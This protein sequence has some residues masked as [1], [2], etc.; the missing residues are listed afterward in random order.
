MAFGILEIAAIGFLFIISLLALLGVGYLFLR[1]YDNL[2]KNPDYVQK[3]YTDG[4]EFSKNNCPESIYNFQLWVATTE[5]SEGRP[6]GR[7]KGYAY[8]PI[9]SFTREED[10]EGKIKLVPEEIGP[11]SY[12]HFI[13]FIPNK[14]VFN[15][16]NPTTW[17]PRHLVAIVKPKDIVG[18]ELN[19][20]LHWNARID[21]YKW[22][23]YAV[24]DKEVNKV[25]LAKK[26]ES[27]VGMDF[28]TDAY[29]K[30]SQLV[31]EAQETDSD[32]KKK[33]RAISEYDSR[34]HSK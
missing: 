17:M 12:R 15:I 7:I 10:E 3:H 34:R 11:D 32:F 21:Y 24:E 6:L 1:Y 13:T 28:A 33:I 30:L 16:L 25:S 26:I 23:I 14:Y 4:I 9:Q 20:N 27:D 31:N 19:G 22:F 29:R 18:K 5:E 2:R 8:V